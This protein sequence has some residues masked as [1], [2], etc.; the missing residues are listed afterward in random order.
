MVQ[1]LFGTAKP[2]ALWFRVSSCS[3]TARCAFTTSMEL[4]YVPSASQRALDTLYLLGQLWSLQLCVS[5]SCPVQ[6]APP[7]RGSG[8]APKVREHLLRCTY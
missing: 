2:T 7:Y 5:L 3:L 4:P 8:W 1:V 6:F